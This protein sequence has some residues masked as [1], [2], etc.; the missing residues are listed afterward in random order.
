MKT[1]NL[2]KR[3][4]GGIS[5]LRTISV[6]FAVI[7]MSVL[8]GCTR[9]QYVYVNSNLPKSKS[10]E[11]IQENDSFSV[12]YVFSGENLGVS[13]TIFNKLSEPVFFD[14]ERSTIFV[15]GSQED[16]S[17]YNDRQV[18]SISPNSSAVVESNV[19]WD[20][21][22]KI[23][24]QDTIIN[25]GIATPVKNKGQ[26]HLY[27]DASSPIYLRCI[28]SLSTKSDFTSPI[29]IDNSFWVSEIFETTK[30]PSSFK[31][32]PA[33]QFYFRRT[34]GFGKFMGWTSGISLLIVA[35]MLDTGEE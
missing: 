6:L 10:S 9:Y 1:T 24:P 14:W 31:T 8:T 17:F 30:G 5:R 27:E 13:L 35:A 16:G 19:L 15:N 28:L 12:K 22:I 4:I 25:N 11:F 23:P 32:A 20:Q 29:F 18:V 26:L 3:Y 33:N 21:F 7:C 2:N 34:T